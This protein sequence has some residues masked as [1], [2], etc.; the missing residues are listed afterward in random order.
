MA[1]QYSNW[2]ARHRSRSG[3]AGGGEVPQFLSHVHATVSG[4]HRSPDAK[5]P[6]PGSCSTFTDYRKK[7]VIFKFIF[8]NSSLHS[9]GPWHGATFQGHPVSVAWARVKFRTP[10]DFCQVVFRTNVLLDEDEK[11]PDIFLSMSFP[12]VRQN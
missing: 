12:P 5:K 1:G 9:P 2:P 3:E 11:R 7:K 4:K 10:N 8:W 6:N